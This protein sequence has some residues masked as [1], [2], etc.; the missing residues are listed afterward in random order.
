MDITLQDFANFFMEKRGD[1]GP[2]ECPVC[3][4]QHFVVSLNYQAAPAELAIG[5]QPP[6]GIVLPGH[7]SYFAFSCTNCG[8]ADFFNAGSVRAWKE[9][10]E[11]L[12]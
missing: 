6:P 5:I 12:T 7:H 10:R 8:H 11:R 2:Y 1:Q 9:A 3:R 4:S